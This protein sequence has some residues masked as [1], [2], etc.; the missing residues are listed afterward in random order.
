MKVIQDLGLARA[1][2]SSMNRGV[3]PC[4]MGVSQNQEYHFGGPCNKDYSIW[5]GVYTMIMQKI[6]FIGNPAK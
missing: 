1:L 4:Y 3:P 6:L 2:G 5:G